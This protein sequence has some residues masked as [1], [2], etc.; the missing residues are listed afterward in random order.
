VIR[1]LVET[2]RREGRDVLYEHELLDVLASRGLPVP[3]HR[4]LSRAD[5]DGRAGLG[6]LDG[7]DVVLK[8]V[9]P[10]ILHK[11]DVGGVRLLERASP[12]AVGAT[13]REILDGLPSEL[14]GSV[15]GF[16]IEARV[17]FEPGLGRELLVGLKRNV[18]F[19]P[20]LTL[21]FGGT[22]VEAL[23][24]AL[25]EGQ[26]VV[27]LH[28][29][30]TGASDKRARLHA[31]LFHRWITGAVRGVPALQTSAALDADLD[32][33]I[34]A[35]TDIER[36]VA[37]A[38][39]SVAELELNPLVWS[40]GWRPVDA[41]LRLGPPAEQGEAFPIDNLV[42]GLSPRTVAMVGVSPRMNIGRIILK[43]MLD[44]G[45]PVEHVT[46][47]RDDVPEIDGAR[48]VGSLDELDGPVDLLVL[49]IGAQGVPEVLEPVFAERRAR[50]VLLIPGGMGET[51][52]GRE[53]ASRIDEI[54]ARHA[55]P[56][57]PVLIGNNSLGVVSRKAS[58]DSLF[59]P[60]TKLPRRE[61]G[62][63]P[64]A[65]ISQSGAFVITRLTKLPFLAPDYQISV[66]NQIDARLSH[67]VE[68][69]ARDESIQTYALYIEGCQPGDGARLGALTRALTDQ[70][71]DVIVYRG[72][73]SGLGQVATAGHTASLAGDYRVFTACMRAAG[74]LIA[75]SFD[76]FGDL[77]HLS[78]RLEGKV[79]A[80]LRA[81][82]LSNAGYETVGMADG[83]AGE[84]Y[85]LVPARFAPETCERVTEALSA[86]RIASLINVANPLDIT[87]MASDEVHEACAA[88][89]LDDPGVDLAVAGM[90]PLTPN[91]Q[92][93]TAGLSRRDV[94][95]AE[96][97]YARRIIALFERVTKPFVVVIDGGPHYDALVDFLIE[98]GV[99]VFRSADRAVRIL[100]IYAMARSGRP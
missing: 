95:D 73:R 39:A 92:S 65:L 74:A 51:E 72:G 12:A 71:R 77:I 55:G 64:V 36:E 6:E 49:A 86:A 50:A 75:D 88:A 31:S 11:S 13:A 94:F 90:V 89:I 67:F 69:V 38:G 43:V 22:Q 80:G 96:L 84:G 3:A 25:L 59:I 15:V 20:V 60:R 58:L 29:S 2:A 24:A 81:G 85:E 19:G 32:A 5:T 91:V 52:A 46:L 30:L 62:L 98:S 28:P 33:W 97:G 48:C 99:P 16:V 63:S 100:G 40:D 41:L 76:D 45:Y 53:I 9:S 83:H 56:D 87:P 23:D 70:G 42:R 21:G 34:E 10:R 61:G 79:F 93:L 8:L 37:A 4:F 7:Q 17:D 18:E 1:R 47:I 66:G 14:A 68:A 26:G 78:A 82:L 27:I 44:N 35:L 54:V 57:R